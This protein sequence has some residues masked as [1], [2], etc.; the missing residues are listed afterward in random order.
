M[1]IYMHDTCI[2]YY[3]SRSLKNVNMKN[4]NIKNQKLFNFFY[5]K[6]KCFELTFEV[7]VKMVTLLCILSKI[8]KM[9]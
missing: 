2:M 9:V 6:T 5:F 4:A 3:D 7:I 1:R 8:I